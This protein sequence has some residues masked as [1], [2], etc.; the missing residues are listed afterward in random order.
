[1]KLAMCGHRFENL[2]YSLDTESYETLELL[3]WKSVS[4]YV[5]SGYDT[6]VCNATRGMG[7]VLGEI[8]QAIKE[9]GLPNIKLI[10]VI[11]YG[12]QT[13]RWDDVWRSR[14]H[15]LLRDANRIIQA[16]D[17]YQRQCYQKQSRCIIDQCDT[18]LAVCDEKGK[19]RTAYAVE[20]AKKQGKTVEIINPFDA[21]VKETKR[22]PPYC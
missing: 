10:C 9:A 3:L 15:Y 11:P 12:E 20:Y 14:Y 8:V 22:M 1:M 17:E 19:G 21:I 6:F 16:C 13:R 4:R 7:I 5:D 18:L 2:P